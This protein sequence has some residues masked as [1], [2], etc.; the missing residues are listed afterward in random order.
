MQDIFL[1]ITR[2]SWLWLL[3]AEIAGC[4][5]DEVNQP[6][7]FDY[8]YT[9]EA[10]YSMKSKHTH[11]KWL[12]F[13]IGLACNSLT[14]RSDQQML[15]RKCLVSGSD[16]KFWKISCIICTEFIH[17]FWNIEIVNEALPSSI[18][19][20]IYCTIIFFYFI[21]FLIVYRTV[22]ILSA[23]SFKQFYERAKVT[24]L[25]RMKYMKHTARQNCKKEIV[26]VQHLKN[27]IVCMLLNTKKRCYSSKWHPVIF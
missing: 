17:S 10:H 2:I 21:V 5:N 8:V 18:H 20:P 11:L 14:L 13:Y 9:S 7:V 22:Q 3:N 27:T 15:Q 4:G 26:R 12:I 16:H 19:H 23:V 6:S 24:H 25:K 1:F